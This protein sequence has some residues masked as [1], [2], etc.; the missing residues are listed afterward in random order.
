[1]LLDLGNVFG[2]LYGNKIERQLSC[3]LENFT[4]VCLDYTSITQ[5]L[6]WSS[7]SSFSKNTRLLFIEWAIKMK[8]IIQ[9]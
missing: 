5:T 4:K 1:M 6:F 2:N 9:F 8:N 7:E 3:K